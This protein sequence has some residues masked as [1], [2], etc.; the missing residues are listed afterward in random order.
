M[1]EVHKYGYLDKLCHPRFP[2]KAEGGGPN[3]M[4]ENTP[5]EVFNFVKFCNKNLAELVTDLEAVRRA[6]GGTFKVDL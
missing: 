3:H 1:E 5:H 2:Q 4:P 6:Q